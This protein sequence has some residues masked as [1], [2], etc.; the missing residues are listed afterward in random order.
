FK[1][2]ALAAVLAAVAVAMPNGPKQRPENPEMSS[3]ATASRKGVGLGIGID[4]GLGI[5]L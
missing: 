4:L 5:H 2:F 3:S 1:L